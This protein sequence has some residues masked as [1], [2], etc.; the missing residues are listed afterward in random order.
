MY[1]HDYVSAESQQDIS[2][3]PSIPLCSC[4]RI[5][6]SAHFNI[7]QSMVR[8]LVLAEDNERGE[9]TWWRSIPFCGGIERS[10]AKQ[11]QWHKDKVNLKDNPL[12][13][14]RG[15]QKRINSPYSSF[16]VSYTG[17]R[18]CFELI[19]RFT[20]RTSKRPNSRWTDS[21]VVGLLHGRRGF[22]RQWTRRSAFLYFGT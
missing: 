22:P 1:P 7:V 19:T 11:Q 17:L 20:N 15:A 10:T 14:K 2:T 8:Y 13:K 5:M 3:F 9:R 4:M 16:R 6:K 21:K 18:M 12:D